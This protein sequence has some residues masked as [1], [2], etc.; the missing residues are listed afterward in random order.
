LPEGAAASP[1]QRLRRHFPDLRY[2]YLVRRNA[3]ARAI[4]HYRAKKTDRWQLDS[5]S[6]SDAGGEGE[7][8][9]DFDAIE[10]FVRLA[11]AEDANWQ[12]FFRQHD[13]RP[14]ELSY[15]ELVLDLE[16]TV[17]RILM[18]LGITAENINVARPNLRQQADRRSKEWEARYRRI[19]AEST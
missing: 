3:V 14:L 10:S 6:A 13:I 18:F 2:I 1:V 4:S 9:F 19:C 17:R 12:Q 5:Q 16:G 15:E 7:P 8:D 11:E